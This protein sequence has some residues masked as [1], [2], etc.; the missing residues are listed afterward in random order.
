MS[1]QVTRR[2]METWL[3]GNGF[4]KLKGG[5]TGHVQYEGPGV[6]ITLPGHGPQDL[7]KKHVALILRA[8]TAAGFDRERVRRE[9]GL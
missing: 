5:M 8:L 6:K 2:E 1:N 3:L 4:R 7:T 9:L